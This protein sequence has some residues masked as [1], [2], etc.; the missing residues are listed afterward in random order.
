M[1]LHRPNS[2][3]NTLR[4]VTFGLALLLS[5]SCYPRYSTPTL[6]EKSP[7]AVSYSHCHTK[8]IPPP[9]VYTIKY[10]DQKGYSLLLKWIDSFCFAKGEFDLRQME[11]VAEWL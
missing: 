8:Q 9:G 7:V 10:F 11:T 3:R 4:L 1:C 2:S 5:K 6:S